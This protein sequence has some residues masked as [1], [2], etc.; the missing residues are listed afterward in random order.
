MS[1]FSEINW[2]SEFAHIAGS[3]SALLLP[4]NTCRVARSRSYLGNYTSSRRSRVLNLNTEQWTD[5][6]VCFEEDSRN[7]IFTGR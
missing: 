4:G 7:G 2:S 3:F 6:C 1:L 5:F